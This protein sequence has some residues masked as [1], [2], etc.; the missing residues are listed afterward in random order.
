M[1]QAASIVSFSGPI[2]FAGVG[3]TI[4]DNKWGG[5]KNGSRPPATGITRSYFPLLARVQE[6]NRLWSWL[7][8]L[9]G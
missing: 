7:F 5:R 9:Q 1:T 4:A 6:S 2:A 8:L 3:R